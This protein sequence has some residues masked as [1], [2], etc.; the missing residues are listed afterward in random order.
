MYTQLLI[1]VCNSKSSEKAGI[2]L[3][4]PNEYQFFYK[5]K[6]ILICHHQERN[7]FYYIELINA[8]T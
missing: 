3:K 4:N 5:C 8:A 7:S 2:S 6:L 1:Q